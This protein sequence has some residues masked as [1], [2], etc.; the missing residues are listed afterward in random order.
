MWRACLAVARYLQHPITYQR[1]ASEVLQRLE[2]SRCNGGDFCQLGRG[3][4][5]A[6]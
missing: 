1:S 3:G 5:Y 4:Q 6:I 2:V